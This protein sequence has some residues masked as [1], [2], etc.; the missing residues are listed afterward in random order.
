MDVTEWPQPRRSGIPSINPGWGHARTVV[1][2]GDK[3]RRRTTQEE[4][5][6]RLLSKKEFA[7]Q[8]R[9]SERT[10]ERWVERGWLTK[11]RIGGVV[12]FRPED[13]EALVQ[14][15]LVAAR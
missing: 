12:R 14:R 2:G 3:F 4:R 6:D 5:M 8:F 15:G 10:V 1:S 9:V 13:G 7:E 11:V